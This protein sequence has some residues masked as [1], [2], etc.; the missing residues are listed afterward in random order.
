MAENLD[1]TRDLIAEL[2]E[3]E[4]DLILGGTALSIYSQLKSA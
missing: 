1:V 2:T 4:R 3:Q